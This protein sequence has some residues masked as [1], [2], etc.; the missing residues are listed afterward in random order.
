MKPLTIA[1]SL[2]MYA[3]LMGIES[4]ELI[5]VLSAGAGVEGFL[6]FHDEHDL[7]SVYGYATDG[8]MSESEATHNVD[9]MV[10]SDPLDTH[11]TWEAGKSSWAVAA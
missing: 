7:T 2:D 5:D 10:V 3:A 1:E 6:G 9:S 8:R 4:D 11:A